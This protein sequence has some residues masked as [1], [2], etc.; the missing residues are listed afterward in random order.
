MAQY[1]SHFN[2]QAINRK[3][4]DGNIAYG[5]F[6]LNSQWWCTNSSQPSAN[7]CSP[8]CSKFLDDNIDD[9]IRCAK[10]VVRDPK[11]MFAWRAWIK[12]CKGRDLSK[13]LADCNL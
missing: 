12:H 2:T 11:R 6:Q 9:D 3:N 10:R 1:E 8:T 5:L 13:Y 4:A 7:A